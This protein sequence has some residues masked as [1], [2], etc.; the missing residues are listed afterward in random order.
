MSNTK[1]TEKFEGPGSKAE[2]GV[3]SFSPVW[4]KRNQAKLIIKA[5]C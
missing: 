2:A 3:A 5:L 1:A 4:S